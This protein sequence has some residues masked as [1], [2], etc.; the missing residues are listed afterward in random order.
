MFYDHDES[1][2][3]ALFGLDIVEWSLLLG[4]IALIAFFVVLA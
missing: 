1:R 4:A 2:G 3:G